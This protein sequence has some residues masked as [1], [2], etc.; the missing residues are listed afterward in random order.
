MYLYFW[1]SILPLTCNYQKWT[2]V[3]RELLNYFGNTII[4][5]ISLSGMFGIS[6]LISMLLDLGAFLTAHIV[7]TP[8]IHIIIYM[9]QKQQF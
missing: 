7:S 8:H 6:V 5:V 2:V 3:T 9:L 1:N 4:W